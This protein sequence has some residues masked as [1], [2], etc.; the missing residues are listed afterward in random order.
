MLR[1]FFLYVARVEMN[2]CLDMYFVVEMSR[3]FRVVNTGLT[4]FC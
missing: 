4:I 3:N 1:A 2:V